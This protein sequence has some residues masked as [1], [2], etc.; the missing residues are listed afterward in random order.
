MVFA[1][2]SV[3]T[4]C[5]SCP[6]A[7]ESLSFSTG[8]V[9]SLFS[10][11][12]FV[13]LCVSSSL[14]AFDFLSMCLPSLWFSPSPSPSL[15]LA[16]FI[17]ISLTSPLHYLFN[18]PWTPCQVLLVSDPDTK[19]S[20]AA[21]DVHVGHFSD[22]GKHTT[23]PGIIIRHIYFSNHVLLSLSCWFCLIVLA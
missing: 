14:F 4:L 3:F 18:A 2:N 1:M 13:P 16:L 19:T 22:P 6:S 15:A 12:L 10:V 5:F 20:A 8:T 23:C 7:S 9:L 21:M 17:Q 11:S